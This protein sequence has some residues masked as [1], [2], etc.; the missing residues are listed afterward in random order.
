MFTVN[1]CCTKVSDVYY[2]CMQNKGKSVYAAQN[3][4]VV[5]C[6]SMMHKGKSC[7]LSSV[8]CIHVVVVNS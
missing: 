5:Y 2:Q 3:A 1:V 4:C 6:Q 8:S 7:S